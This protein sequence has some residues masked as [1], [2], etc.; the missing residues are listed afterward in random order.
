MIIRRL[1]R[2]EILDALHLVWEVFAQ[3]VAPFYTPQGVASFQDFIRYPSI[4]QKI[5]TEGLAMFGAYE[6]MEL[7]GAGAVLPTGHI[8]LLFVRR[9]YQHQGIGKALFTEMCG[10]AGQ[11]FRVQQVTVNAAPGAVNA[12]RH[13]GM[14][15]AAP[16]QSS[17][18]MRYTPMGMWVIA[19]PARRKKKG[20]FLAA[21]IGAA[22]LALLIVA[23]AALVRETKYAAENGSGSGSFS[24]P[25]EDG[26]SVWDW[27]DEYYDD[28]YGD[29]DPGEDGLTDSQESGIDA[30]DAHVD[31]DCG[32][33]VTESDYTYTAENT[34]SAAIQFEVYY[35]QVE[36]LGEKVQEK[37]NTALQD[38]ALATVD[39]LY[40]EPSDEMKEKVLGEENPVLASFVE[41]KVTY[42]SPSLLSV[43]FQDYSYEGSAG[44]V[45]T[46]LRCCNVNLEDG[47][48]YQV[49]D[50]AS[51]DDAFI[52]LWAQEMRDEAEDSA[53]LAELGEED[54]K[55]VLGG[56]TK[57]GV[58]DAQF[59][60][61]ADGVEI[62][63]SFRYPADSP[64]NRGYAW[65][66]APFDYDETGSFSTDST[67]WSALGR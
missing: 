20:L 6:G 46:S 7:R 58:Y 67:F 18:G 40:L 34:T 47:T 1:D 26:P 32:Y 66:T 53:L 16:E 17:G 8:A 55:A 31:P 48:V 44:D 50:I 33:Q 65:V 51:L 60:A 37:V 22:C 54:M 41:Y 52:S 11:V 5:Q 15:D 23:S 27:Y 14:Y 21:G 43:V 30:I 45:Y 3:D 49:K 38:C 36:G 62:G 59:F 4:E 56:D 61:D 24:V 57:D 28:F 25:G 2:Q 9:Q 29:T 39:K 42:Q 13:M 35:P 64:D 12:F 63:L 10:F 19:A